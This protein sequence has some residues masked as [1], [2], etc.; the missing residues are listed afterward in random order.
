MPVE[1][2]HQHRELLQRAPDRA[3]GA[4]R[5]LHQEPGR[6]R[7]VLE[8]LLHGRDDTLQPGLEARAEM[9]ADVEDHPLRPDRRGGV[10]RRAHGRDALLVELVVGAG[11]VDEVEG[12]DDGRADPELLTPLAE[13]G[14]VGRIVIGEAPGAGALDE[15]LN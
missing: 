12:V 9:R 1:P 7:A 5:V 3:A 4:G 6:L 10:H 13:R 14:E 15:Q 2:I 11:E 8:D